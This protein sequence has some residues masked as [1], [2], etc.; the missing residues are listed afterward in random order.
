MG[1]SHEQ[2]W[3]DWLNGL[4]QEIENGH[5]PSNEMLKAMTRLNSAVASKMKNFYK[6]NNK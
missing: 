3:T 1:F 4:A 5:L 6:R 2:E